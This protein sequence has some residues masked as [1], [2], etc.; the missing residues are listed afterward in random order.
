MMAQSFAAHQGMQQH[1]GLPPGHP[2]AHAQHPNVIHP[3]AGMVQQVHPGV[4]APGGPQVS[5][6]GPM[7]G[8]MP[9]GAG[10]AGPG[11]PVPNAHALSHLGPTQ[12]HLFQQHQFPQ[13]FANNPQLL[14]QHQQQQLLRQRMILHQQQQQQQQQQHGALP[15]SL[16][17][18]TQG[19]NTAQMAAMQGNPAM[20]PVLQQMHLQQLPHGQPQMQTPQQQQLLALQAQQAQQA[21]AQ[22]ASN[23]G[24]PGQP[25]PQQRAAA[26]PQNI[27]EAQS[28]TP[29]PQPGPAPHQ[30]SSTPQSNPPQPSSQPP[31]PQAA[32]SQPQ[33]T[34]NPPH[35][36]L[37]QSQQPMQQPQHTPQPQPQPHPQQGPQG[38]QQGAQPTPAMT[39]QEA[40]LK[41]QQQQ[42][43]M[44]QQRM[45]MKS[46]TTLYLN[47]F[48]EQLS[49]FRS[50]DEA[51]D[52]L[53]WQEFVDRFYSPAG[54]LRQG[55]YNRQ[56]GSKQFEISTP[57][58]ARYY[59]T[60]FNSGIR[61]IQMLVE[62]VR[63]TASPSGGHIVESAKTSFIY[64]FTNDSQLFTNG[65]LRAYF[66]ANHKIE[67]LDIVVMN[68]TE[69]LPRP[70]LQALEQAE[71][72]KQSPRVSKNTGK[73]GQ[74]RQ[75]NTPSFTLPE[76]MVTDHG[77]PIAVLSFLEVA[78]TISQM[79]MLLHHSQQNP[80]M[81]ATE[82]LRN[83]VNTLQTQQTPNMG[84][85]PTP[86]NP[87]LQPGQ[88]PRGPP[89]NGPAQ[90]A[91]PGMHPLG[92]PG[93]QGSPHITG[94]AH[95]SP[96][97]S[98]LAAPGMIPQGQVQPN[99]HSASASPNVSNKRRR[100]STIKVEGD[101]SGG[102]PEVNGT[103]PQGGAKV[104]AS[105]R[106]TKKQKGGA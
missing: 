69:Y 34:P 65:R 19:L 88:P 77:V 16:P 76:S 31:A 103:G 54:V 72:Q 64:W 37:P 35:Q 61:H 99:A 71:Q 98:H 18:G 36:Q 81:S 24:Q 56:S 93:A 17:N 11:G 51:H 41:A 39:A 13:N 53:Y 89:L 68:H 50:R 12:A 22:Q 29:Q 62:A 47:A 95:A 105:P 96:A 104:K 60:Q 94:S 30:G 38:L 97:P 91:S 20:R 101:D 80:Q 90:F 73:R 4:S 67:M 59:L 92:L 14:Q 21:Q 48:A 70:Q 82:S 43:L 32:T 46:M 78:E 63:E 74:Q 5:Q 3:G 15:V 84:F 106:V 28:V 1:S 58:L 42:N 75:A 66:D 52:L 49:N 40:Q 79:Q 33:P 7:M 100:Q 44:L 86:M 8:A 25:T 55:V 23:A 9:P 26:Q 6:A 87:A 102:A 27:H 57:A 10:T 83:L 2:M 85:M 45:G